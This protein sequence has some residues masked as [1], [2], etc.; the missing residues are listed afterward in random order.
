MSEIKRSDSSSPEIAPKKQKLCNDDLFKVSASHPY[1]IARSGK[2]CSPRTLKIAFARLGALMKIC[3]PVTEMSSLFNVFIGGMPDENQ[4]LDSTG[5]S[6]LG[7]IVEDRV[8]AIDAKLTDYLDKAFAIDVQNDF[9]L[10]F[11]AMDLK[12]TNW[13][14]DEQILVA[15]RC[16]SLYGRVIFKM[17][18]ECYSIL[19]EHMEEYALSEKRMQSLNE[20]EESFC[21][22][23]HMF[24]DSMNTNVVI[25]ALKDLIAGKP[26]R[27]GIIEMVSD[28]GMYFDIDD[29]FRDDDEKYVA[30]DEE[31]E[32]DKDE[33]EC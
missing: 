27:H 33:D 23:Q 26:E 14:N 12:N 20:F 29:I 30:E 7:A 32:E 3:F 15:L 13:T 8:E 17:I 4:T 10:L 6:A 21:M 18:V 9:K 16:F 11:D 19:T 31:E 28:D 25:K 1:F 5:L 24:D 22:F 2:D